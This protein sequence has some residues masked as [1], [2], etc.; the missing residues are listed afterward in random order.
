MLYPWLRLLTCRRV[1][2]GIPEYLAYITFIPLSTIT[3]VEKSY[4]STGPTP[5]RAKIYLPEICYPIIVF[6]LSQKEL[7]VELPP[8][9]WYNCLV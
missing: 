4:I 9:W 5:N 6:R 3:E 8:G 7:F 2:Q 1:Q